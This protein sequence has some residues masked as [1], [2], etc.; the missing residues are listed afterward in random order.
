MAL[1][2]LVYTGLLYQDLI[3]TGEVRAGQKLPAVFPLV[4]YNGRHRWTAARDVGELI[5]GLPA[6]LK[7]YH[8]SPNATSCWSSARSSEARLVDT[9]NTVADII[10][11]ETSSVPADVQ[12]A[13][14]H[15][16]ETCKAPNTPASDAPSSSGSTE[17]SCGG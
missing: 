8:P 14:A 16:R 4:L 9:Q 17:W 13:V 2:I 11:L 5:E 12:R 15:L 6:S 3:K 1:R 10:R 7:R